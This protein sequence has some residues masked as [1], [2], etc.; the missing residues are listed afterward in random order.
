M[1]EIAILGSSVRSRV[2][3]PHHFPECPG[4]AFTFGADGLPAELATRRTPGSADRTRAWARPEVPA[5]SPFFSVRDERPWFCF[6]FCNTS[7]KT[8]IFSGPVL[9]GWPRIPS[10]PSV[11]GHCHDAVQV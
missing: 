1:A 5:P 4:R 6:W 2:S 11:P 3:A 7:E 9:D 10:A 8:D